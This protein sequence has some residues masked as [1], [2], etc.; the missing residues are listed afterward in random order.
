M[1][2]RKEV[3]YYTPHTVSLDD[4]KKLWKALGF[5]HRTMA[6]MMFYCCLRFKDVQNLTIRDIFLKERLLCLRTQKNGTKD[7]YYPLH[8]K[9]V[10][11]LKKYI[12][13]KRYLIYESKG[14][15]FP[16]NRR[17]KMGVAGWQESFI[18]AR[19]KANVDGGVYHTTTNGHKLRRLTPHSM[20][21]VRLQTAELQGLTLNELQALGHH[22]SWLSTMRYLRNPV[23]N[24]EL[25]KRAMSKL[26]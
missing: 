7:E 2:L 9:I 21:A 26:K 8:P 12:E 18:R 16:S 23:E 10:I 4:V 20:K 19:E 11:I 5:K 6:Q 22:R 15:L 13:L 1:K 14:L 25:K 3:R 24:F 17:G